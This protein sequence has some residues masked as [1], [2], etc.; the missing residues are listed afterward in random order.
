MKALR[1][2]IPVVT[3]VV[4]TAFVVLVSVWLTSLV[5]DSEWSDFLKAAIIVILVGATLFV[6]AWSAY[7]SY[8]IREAIEKYLAGETAS[9]EAKK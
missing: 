9:R 7:F 4:T 1:I 2:I 6:I 5:P 3:T 8:V